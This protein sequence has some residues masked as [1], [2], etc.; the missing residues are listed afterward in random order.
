[1]RTVQVGAP[2]GGDDFAAIM[3]AYTAAAAGPAVMEFDVGATYLTSQPILIGDTV[4]CPPAIFGRETTIKATV[5]GGSVVTVKG[6]HFW[7]ENFQMEG[8][9]L[10]A[11]NLMR[12]GFH[13]TGTTKG[14]FSR[15]TGI[16]TAG[17]FSANIVA[18][19]FLE[20]GVGKG[21][22]SCVLDTVE[23]RSGANVG[24]ALYDNQQPSGGSHIQVNHLVNLIARQNARGGFYIDGWQGALTNARA[25]SNLAAGYQFGDSTLGSLAL[26]GCYAEAN[27][28]TGATGASDT[29]ISASAVT[30]PLVSL[31]A[32]RIIGA[33]PAGVLNF[34]C[35][36]G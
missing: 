21:I 12:V 35:S 7:W 13:L 36:R 3:A 6:P 22:Y 27:D 34:G 11:N 24:I 8:F 10:D 32:G 20:G 15:I 28:A 17:D 2:S 26:I 18:G 4:K 9:T 33:V 14:H 16:N 1:M 31:H 5:A 30:A 25:E 23:G 19:I 29:A